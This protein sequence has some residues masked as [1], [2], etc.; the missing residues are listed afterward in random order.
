MLQKDK[1][2]PAR[3]PSTSKILP[4]SLLLLG[5]LSSSPTIVS[6]LTFNSS[7]TEVTH[8]L[9]S[10][11]F[12]PAVIF[13]TAVAAA[14][15]FCLSYE[16]I[17]IY[18]AS[19]LI[20]HGLVL[21]F[22]F[23]ATSLSNN[24]SWPE[25]TFLIINLHY[26]LIV[27]AILNGRDKISR[28]STLA[29]VATILLLILVPF[30]PWLEAVLQQPSTHSI[31]IGAELT[32]FAAIGWTLIKAQSANLIS[33][34]LLLAIPLK[35]LALLSNIPV[36]ILSISPNLAVE[37]YQKASY[38]LLLLGFVLLAAHAI[39][40]T[41]DRYRKIKQWPA[42]LQLLLEALP[43]PAFY[44]DHYRT[45][46]IHNRRFV[47]WFSL[48][49]R[50]LVGLHLRQLL[51][52][53]TYTNLWRLSSDA[54]KG[55]NG[56]T[57][58]SIKDVNDNEHKLEVSLIADNTDIPRTGFF[59]LMI[60]H[61][62][63]EYSE[64]SPESQPLDELA[65][66]RYLS[67]V[68]YSRKRIQ[69]QAELLKQQS[70]EL[71]V[72]RDQALSATQAKSAFLANM[73]H[74]LRTPLNGIVTMAALLNEES[75]SENQ[76]ECADIIKISSEAL[77]TIINDVLDFSKIE[78]GK[79]TIAPHPFSLRDT[80]R[81]LVALLEP[82][83]NAKEITFVQEI[84]KN[85]PDQLIGDDGRIRQV[86]INLLSNA[87]KFT[88]QEGAII[89]LIQSSGGDEN[90]SQI[91]ISVADTGIGIADDKQNQIFGT[92]DQEDSTTSRHYGGTGLGLS[93][94]RRL[95]ELMKGRIWLNSKKGIGSCFTFTLTLDRQT[96]ISP[97][98]EEKRTSPDHE[99]IPLTILVAED[100]NM[101]QRVMLRLLSL[102]GHTVEIV[103]NGQLALNEF[104]SDTHYD[105]ILM[106]CHMPEMDG[107]AAT[108]A[109]R[110]H[111]A[112]HGGHIPIIGLTA[113]TIQN[114]L[115]E[116]LASGMDEYVTKP[117]PKEM[118][119][120]KLQYYAQQLL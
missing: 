63:Q 43:F 32:L 49:S 52:K 107:Y 86:I 41:G 102:M 101:N 59:G 20:A 94:S 61:Q 56:Q 34:L 120:D 108:R 98:S 81:K 69:E 7:S 1:V 47:E 99:N 11:S 92:F 36:N 83:L 60:P 110:Q 3:Y 55:V 18:M 74:E 87:I 39:Y 119:Q 29:I 62:H 33:S 19:L 23:P 90:T 37:Q 71:V 93:I 50:S 78:A 67:E 8:S 26:A 48:I 64:T 22:L 72:A 95:V 68:E 14:I 76:H 57:Q 109:I 105:L 117:V 15:I 58:L 111:E 114:E 115:D 116:C 53:K 6:L 24:I 31:A 42:K 44:A 82:M 70:E 2:L 17:A 80:I 106:D 13:L 85:V 84:D 96:E 103:A 46:Q 100:N 112:N 51:G 45:V 75:L 77:L 66:Q 9:G 25:S 79:L 89:L 21:L 27:L 73:S 118:L 12:I 65:V 113:A 30:Q 97:T 28:V 35:V 5:V 104:L 38:S 91:Q 54:L 4:I 88:P 40:I 10:F 16:K